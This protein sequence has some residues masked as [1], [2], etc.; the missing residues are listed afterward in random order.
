MPRSIN[1]NFKKATASLSNSELWEHYELCL[2]QHDWSYQY[3]DDFQVWR[4][5]SD[6][7]TYLV[8]LCDKLGAIDNDRSTNLFAKYRPEGC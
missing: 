6:E 5:G 2:K 7:R 8:N 3:S 1:Q 4:V